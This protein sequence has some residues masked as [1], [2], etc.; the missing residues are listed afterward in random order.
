MRGD[1]YRSQSRSHDTLAGAR[2]GDPA[3]ARSGDMRLLQE[4]EQETD[5]LAGAREGDRRPLKELDHGT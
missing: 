4:P 3:G 2:A 5:T 1:P